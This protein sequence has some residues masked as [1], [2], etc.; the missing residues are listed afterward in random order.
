MNIKF[1]ITSYC[2]WDVQVLIATGKTLALSQLQHTYVFEDMLTTKTQKPF[3]TTLQFTFF[4]YDAE[5]NTPANFRV[6]GGVQH[7]R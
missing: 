3:T 2:Y 5:K 6:Q 7:V 1:L 4:F